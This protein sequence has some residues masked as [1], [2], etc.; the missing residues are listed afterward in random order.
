MP[1]YRMI[2]YKKDKQS[3]A[4]KKTIIEEE[5]KR[6]KEAF[7]EHKRREEERR[8]KKRSRKIIEAEEG[9]KETEEEERKAKR[10]KLEKYAWRFAPYPCVNIPIP[11]KRAVL[12]AKGLRYKLQLFN[13]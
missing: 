4:F 1:S 12:K 10:R 3:K 7:A 8:G 2:K 6:G 5:E 13:L 11:I 9:E